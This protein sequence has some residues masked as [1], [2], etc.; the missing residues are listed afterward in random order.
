MCPL[1]SGEVIPATIAE[2]VFLRMKA[3]PV[4]AASMTT[5]PTAVRIANDATRQSAL[6]VLMNVRIAESRYAIDARRYAR[7]VKEDF[8]RIV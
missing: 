7:N 8:V 3:I 1:V 4:N 6:A 5:A 2:A